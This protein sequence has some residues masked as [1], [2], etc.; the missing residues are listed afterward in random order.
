MLPHRRCRL[1]RM[2]RHAFPRSCRASAT[3]VCGSCLADR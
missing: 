1:S 2:E 3:I